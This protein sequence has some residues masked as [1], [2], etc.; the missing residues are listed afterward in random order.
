MEVLP[1]ASVLSANPTAEEQ[2]AHQEERERLEA[3]RLLYK[4]EKANFRAQ[5]EAERLERVERK[6]RR[7]KGGPEASE[8]MSTLEAAF[9]HSP[10]AEDGEVPQPVRPTD[11]PGLFAPPTHG[12]YTVAE[13]EDNETWEHP[14]LPHPQPWQRPMRGPNHEQNER[15]IARLADMGFTEASQ[16]QLPGIV[17][18]QTKNSLTKSDDEIIERILEVLITADGAKPAPRAGPSSG[19]RRR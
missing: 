1:E 16:P 14:P 7:E 3:A 17:R 18:Q 5:R 9:G 8:L 10:R 2:S 15:L 13:P 19:N 12:H 6:A 11:L 4:Q